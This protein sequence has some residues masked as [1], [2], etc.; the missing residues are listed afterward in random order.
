M[1]INQPPGNQSRFYHLHYRLMAVAVSLLLASMSQILLAGT[2]INKQNLSLSTQQAARNNAGR[3]AEIKELPKIQ[4]AIIL[5]TSNSMDGLIDQTRNQ[6]WQ[7]I[8][9]FS[10]ARQNGVT[11]ILEIALFEYGNSANSAS[12]GFVRMLNPFTRELDEVSAGLFSLTTNGGYEYCGFAIETVV[13]ELQWSRSSTDIK[14]IFIAG[15][16]SFSQGPVSYVHAIKLAS[17][18]GISINTIH[19]GEHQEGV[20]NGWQSA[21]MLAGGD[22]LS[23]DADLQVV[24][25]VAPQ[26]VKIAELNARLNQTYVPYGAE[27]ADKL[28]RQQQQDALSS[29]ISAGLLAQRAKSK[30]SSF[31]SNSTWDLVDALKHGDVDEEELVE[32]E[33]AALPEPMIGLTSK[34]KID[35]VRQKAEA[36]DIIK[37]EINELSR[38]R[39]AYVAEQKV[40]QVAA[41]PSI[42]DALT[43]AV[44][45]QAREKNFTFED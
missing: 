22:Y 10:T 38:S 1:Q 30:S 23:I 3:V 42:S 26:D 4:L 34:Q 29:E 17:Q 20:A 14:T 31:Y 25:I 37:R 5:D 24:H 27:A 13:N 39:A 35:F 18:Y 2:D 7:V 44:K 36:R 32:I 11:P 12:A 43:S 15:N 45:K 28:E 33:D 19:A 41:A 16:E 40:E 21:A 6:L 8:N 9:E